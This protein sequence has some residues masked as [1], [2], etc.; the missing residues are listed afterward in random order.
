VEQPRGD[1]QDFVNKSKHKICI[2]SVPKSN[3]NSI[4]F[5]LLTWT[6][7]SSK[8]SWPKFLHDFSLASSSNKLSFYASAIPFCTYDNT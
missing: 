7:S 1:A 2:S 6:K 8:T 3:E 4:K 5:S